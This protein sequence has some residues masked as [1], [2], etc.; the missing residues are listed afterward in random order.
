[1]TPKN[2][3]LSML[4]SLLNTTMKFNPTTWR[5]LPYSSSFVSD[6]REILVSYSLQLLLVLLSY[7]LPKI[8]DQII[9]AGSIPEGEIAMVNQFRHYYKKLHRS[10]DFSFLVEGMSRVLQQPIQASSTYLPGS[11]RPLRFHPEMMMLFWETLQQNKRFRTFL[12]E[13]DRALDFL[14]L[15]LFYALEHKTEPSQIGLVRMCVFILQPLSAEPKFCKSLTKR[16][17]G[18]GALP[19]SVRIPSFRGSYADFM[20]TVCFPTCVHP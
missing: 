20:I 10:N 4:C 13:T 19:A 12:I 14:V 9:Y 11:Q 17:E 18:H 1:M 15:L 3:V 2:V 7:P 16:F 6:A 5:T 8:G